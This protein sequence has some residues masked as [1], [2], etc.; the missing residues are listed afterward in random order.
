[1]PEM[2]GNS[3]SIHFLT[4][5]VG[6]G[7]LAQ[8]LLGELRTSFLISSGGTGSNSVNNVP[9]YGVDDWK[10]GGGSI[11]ALSSLERMLSIFETLEYTVHHFL[12]RRSFNLVHNLSPHAK[13]SVT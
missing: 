2:D 11:S 12:S 10:A 13:K 6:I 7:S 5:S 9:A 8:H 3:S 1:M 4:M